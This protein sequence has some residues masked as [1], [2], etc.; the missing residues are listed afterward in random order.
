[1]W[2]HGPQA[3]RAA[4][5]RAAPVSRLKAAPVAAA[6]LLSITYVSLYPNQDTKS[7]SLCALG[8][9]VVKND[10][11]LSAV[12]YEVFVVGERLDLRE[13]QRLDDQRHLGHRR[14]LE[15]HS[16]RQIDLEQRAQPRDQLRAEQRVSA[17]LEKIIVAAD[18]R[19]AKQLLPD[20][21]DPLLGRALRLDI[22]VCQLRS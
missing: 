4:A 9:F 19:D 18:R 20:L 21:G 3:Y 8:A 7:A 15:Q 10:R 2:I 16:E 22:R 5:F 1:M 11:P 6:V 12:M 13:Q 17:Q 14:R